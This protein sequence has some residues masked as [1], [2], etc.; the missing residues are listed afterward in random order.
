MRTHDEQKVR[1]ETAAKNS[2]ERTAL[3]RHQHRTAAAVRA[4]RYL[5]RP[6]KLSEGELDAVR[7]Y[8]GE[9]TAERLATN[10]GCEVEDV[11]RAMVWVAVEGAAAQGG[12][13]S[14]GTI[15]DALV[16]AAPPKG[17]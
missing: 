2:R 7:Q 13:R 5:D 16:T 6:P 4:V 14:P 12:A 8:G 15:F 3:L 10:L 17:T 11:R 9:V 1:R